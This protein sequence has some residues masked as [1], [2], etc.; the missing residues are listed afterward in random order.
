MTDVFHGDRDGL[1]ATT[2]VPTIGEDLPAPIREG[3]ARR[4]LVAL[5]KPCPCG[6]QPYRLNRAQRREIEA[7]KRRGL[8]GQVIRVTIEH[9]DDCPATDENL[10]A[11]AAEHGA[12]IRR[13]M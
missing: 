1:S 3:L 4:R 13:W 9:E 5:G 8:P 2:I 12:T 11:L 10:D 6:A 7:R